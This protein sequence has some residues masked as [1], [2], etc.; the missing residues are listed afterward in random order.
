IGT[1]DTGADRRN[2]AIT[3]RIIGEAEVDLWARTSAAGWLTEH[4]SLADFMF[5]FGQVSA[6]CEG[7]HP[8]LAE[9]DGQPIAA[10]MLFIHGDVAML[11]GAS[12]IPDARN[13][14]AQNALLYDRRKFAADQGC[15][16]ASMAALPGGQSQINAQKNGFQIA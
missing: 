2:A 7:S 4:E 15:T 8:F 14:G 10:G 5:G 16:L 13:R 3:T 12:T 6:L 11:A 1:S 9:L